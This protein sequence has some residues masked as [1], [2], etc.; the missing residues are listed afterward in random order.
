MVFWEVFACDCFAGVSDFGFVHGVNGLSV[1]C[2]DCL[3]PFLPAIDLRLDL[4]VC[5]FV[6]VPELVILERSIAL[7]IGFLASFF[8]FSAS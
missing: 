4:L 8:E 5:H 2:S 3:Y 6:D 1:G 7:G